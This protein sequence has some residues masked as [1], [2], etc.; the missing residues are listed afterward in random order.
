MMDKKAA[1]NSSSLKEGANQTAISH[2]LSIKSIFI[3]NLFR[4]IFIRSKTSGYM[5][6]DKAVAD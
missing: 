5:P 6:Q 2:T 4:R 3:I 1:S